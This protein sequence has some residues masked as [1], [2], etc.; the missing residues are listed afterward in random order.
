MPLTRCAR[1]RTRSRAQGDVE[2]I[3]GTG[4]ACFGATL[5]MQLAH[6]KWAW[7]SC[8]VVDPNLRV[9]GTSGLRV[10]RRVRDATVN[11]GPDKRA[12]THMIAGRAAKLVLG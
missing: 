11:H 10:A 12:P 7:I 8:A 9:H 4:P 3:Q 1:D 6:A 5:E 2:E